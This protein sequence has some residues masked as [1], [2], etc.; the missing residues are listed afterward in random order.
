MTTNYQTLEAID[1]T[2]EEEKKPRK[3]KTPLNLQPLSK[4]LLRLEN[5]LTQCGDKERQKKLLTT[6]MSM[7][8]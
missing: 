4:Q 3:E 8:E 7:Y 1:E 2:I 5:L 6:L